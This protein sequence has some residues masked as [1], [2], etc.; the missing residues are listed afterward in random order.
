[1]ANLVFP[2]SPLILPIA[3]DRWSPESYFTS[4]ISN[5]SMNRSSK[6]NIAIASFNS[7]PNINDFKKSVPFCNPFSK[8]D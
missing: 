6:R 5:V 3:L 4:F 2:F 7:N 8:V 1:M